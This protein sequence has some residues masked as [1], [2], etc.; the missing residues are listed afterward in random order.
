[1]SKEITRLNELIRK[2]GFRISAVAESIDVAPS[3]IFRWTDT[4]PIG[5]L[6][7][8]SRFTGIPLNDIVKCLVSD[9]D[10]VVE[11]LAENVDSLPIGVGGS[12]AFAPAI[13]SAQAEA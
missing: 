4:A 8:M 7:K 2:R 11:P 9:E 12:G 13:A 5:K 3:T 10:S 6:V 1:M